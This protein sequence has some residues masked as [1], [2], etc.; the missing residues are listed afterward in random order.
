MSSRILNTEYVGREL[1]M[2]HLH[3][4]VEQQRPQ[5]KKPSPGRRQLR[6]G[7][8]LIGAADGE[9][10]DRG[11]RVTAAVLSANAVQVGRRREVDFQPDVKPYWPCGAFRW[12]CA[13][14]V[15]IGIS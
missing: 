1:G 4:D 7:E 15:R 13:K 10:V 2:L 9:E 6:L 12:N 11:G 5:V 8:Q 14:E 3:R